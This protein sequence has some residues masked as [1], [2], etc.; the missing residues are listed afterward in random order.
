MMT[1]VEKTLEEAL[2]VALG[3]S[4]EKVR[5]ILTDPDAQLALQGKND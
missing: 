2:S 5:G 1:M 3:V 4:A